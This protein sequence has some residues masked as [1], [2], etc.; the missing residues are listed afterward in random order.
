MGSF[1]IVIALWGPSKC[2]CQCWEQGQNQTWRRIVYHEA[3]DRVVVNHVG[4]LGQPR[5]LYQVQEQV[6]SWQ[7]GTSRGLRRLALDLCISGR[8]TTV[9]YLC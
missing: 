7:Y 6:L 9:V 4:E 1:A 5:D 3:C 2:L 8:R